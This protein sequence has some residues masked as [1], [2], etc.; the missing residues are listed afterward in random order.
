[1]R[2]LPTV[3][4]VLVALP[5][6]AEEAS[7]CLTPEEKEQ[8]FVCLFDGTSLDQWQGDTKGYVIEDGVLVCKPGGNLYTKKEY[9]DF[10][11]RFEFKLTPNAN[12]GVG[13]RTPLGCDPA[14]CGMEIQ[15]L[16]DSGSQYTQL[17]PYQYHGSIYGVVPAKRGHLKPV[18]EW[19]SEEILCQ[20]RHVRVTLNGVVIVDANLD[21]VQPMDHR[22]HPGLK[23]DKGYIGFLGH[24]TRVEFRRIRIKELK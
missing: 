6:W 20:G 18:G 16:D 2:L 11:F 7:N 5:V 21:E 13:I 12:N 19:N 14:Y 1:M 3:V 10:I 15:I 9:S 8:G 17:Q 4:L 22:D 23:R 24:G